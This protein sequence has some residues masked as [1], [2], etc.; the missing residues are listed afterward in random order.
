[1]GIVGRN[2]RLFSV[3]VNNNYFAEKDHPELVHRRPVFCGRSFIGPRPSN[4]CKR[5]MWEIGL[6]V[7]SHCW[8]RYQAIIIATFTL[9][10]AGDR[11]GR[12]ETENGPRLRFPRTPPHA[13]PWRCTANIARSGGQAAAGRIDPGQPGFGKSASGKCCFTYFSAAL[14]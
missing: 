1:M 9:I 5:G 8:N 13:A 11:P 4:L 12:Q 3:I 10:G 6:P 7:N 14:G 2:M